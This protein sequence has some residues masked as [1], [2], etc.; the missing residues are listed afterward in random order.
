M[1]YFNQESERLLFRPLTKEDIPGWIEFFIDNENLRFFGF[2]P[3]KTVEELS[4]GWILKQLDRYE[5]EGWGLLAAIE[6]ESGK[7]IGMTGI[8]PRELDGNTYYEIAYSYKPPFWGKGYA[9][10]AALQMKKHAN[11]FLKNEQLISI[12]DKENYRSIR[13]A[14]KNEME[15]LFETVYYEMD[16]FVFGIKK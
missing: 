3:E 11:Q 4:E 15:I 9:T 7:F 6:K 12:I 10:E 2:D 13:V 8:I 5:T 14:Q 16:V 1:S